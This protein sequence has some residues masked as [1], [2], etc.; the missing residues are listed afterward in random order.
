MDIQQ[1]AADPEVRERYFAKV[2]KTADGCW[3]WIGAI[4]NRGHGRF[5]TGDGHVVIAHRLGWAIAHPGEPLPPVVAHGECDNPL[6]QNPAHWSA[7]TNGQNRREWAARRHRLGSALRAI[8]VG[9]RGQWRVELTE[10]D[11][12]IERA[13]RAAEA[14][15][16]DE[17]AAD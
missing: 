7:S 6:C 11:A 12:Y 5:W 15:I 13:Y 9:G 10:L 8:R 4:S 17:A 3:L 2:R 16:S 1:A 14:A